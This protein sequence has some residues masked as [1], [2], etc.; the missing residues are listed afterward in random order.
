MDQDQTAPTE[1]VWSAST[2]FV[3]ETSN[4]LVDEKTYILWLCALRVDKCE[5]S[6]YTV[7][8]Y[9][10]CTHVCAAQTTY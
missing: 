8:I 4:I 10:L 6:V 2:L 9:M 3:F 1:A 5:F 7:K